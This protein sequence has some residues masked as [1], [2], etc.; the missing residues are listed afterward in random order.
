MNVVKEIYM[1]DNVDIIE[2]NY[3]PFYTNKKS[4]T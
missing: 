3:I 1:Q 2:L 4:L